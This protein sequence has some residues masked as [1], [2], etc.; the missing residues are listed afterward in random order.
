MAP[1]ARLAT[2]AHCNEASLGLA[3]CSALALTVALSACS[4]V[5]P[6]ASTAPAGGTAASATVSAAAPPAYHGRPR[7]AD[8]AAGG[9]HIQYRLYGRGEPVVVLVHGWSCDS[10]YWAQQIKPL[11]ARYTVATVDLA[12]HGAS[13]ANRSDWSMA[14]FGAD[15]A[16]V[17]S[18]LPG[19]SKVVLVGHSMGA[20]VVAEAA[21]LLGDRVL[22]IIAVDNFQTVGLPLPTAA[23]TA[24][25]LAPFEKDFIGSTRAL[26]PAAFF[27]KDADPALMR[28]IAD[29]MSQEP[30]Q[31]AI[32]AMRAYSV[33]DGARRLAALHQPIIAINSDLHGVTDEA[34]I[35]KF[36]P[37]FRV[38]TIAQ[39]GHFLM[40]EHPR[41][42]NEV[43]LQQLAA[44]TH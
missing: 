44:L 6:P 1:K 40:M 28:R 27:R 31:V 19:G 11:A 32:P 39:T 35:R 38:V 10:N 13:G 16:A 37:Q 29:D 18:A 12:G 36:V 15:V 8:S 23:D 41:E 30:P 14:A 17:V 9:V 22:G 33:W 42:F 34:R 4:R 7:I 25:R 43:L 24:K 2:A 5:A 26:V 21:H 20:P 3:L